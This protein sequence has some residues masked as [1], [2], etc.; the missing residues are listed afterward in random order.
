MVLIGGMAKVLS[1][2]SGGVDSSVATAL[3]LEQW[4][5]V[6]W[7]YMKYWI[8]EANIASACPWSVTCPSASTCQPASFMHRP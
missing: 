2:M 6:T 7:A 4:H 1:A 5:E 8:N 3:L